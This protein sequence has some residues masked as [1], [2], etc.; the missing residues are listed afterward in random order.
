VGRADTDRDSYQ[1][2]RAGNI[3]PLVH[4]WLDTNP[5]KYF[6]DITGQGKLQQAA[7]N[8]GLFPT[9]PGYDEATGVGTPKFAAIITG[10]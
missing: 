6:N 4:G 2:G 8:N 10:R 7:P 3:N 1:G 9:T 5:C